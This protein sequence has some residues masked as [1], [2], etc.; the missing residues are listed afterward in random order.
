MDSSKIKHPSNSKFKQDQTASNSKFK[1]DQA[2]E[3]E[4]IQA[5]S[6]QGKIAWF[7][8]RAIVRAKVD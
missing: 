8:V 1:Q 3:Q 6:N 7:L 5:R 2:S 4:W